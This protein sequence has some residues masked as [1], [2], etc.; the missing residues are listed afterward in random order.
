MTTQKI[1]DMIR[2]DKKCLP[3]ILLQKI[4]GFIAIC[5]TFAIDEEN[6]ITRMELLFFVGK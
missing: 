1:Y 6:K 5:N 3:F 4:M 2:V